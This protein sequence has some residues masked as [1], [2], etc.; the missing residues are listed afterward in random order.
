MSTHIQLFTRNETSNETGD[1]LSYCGKPIPRGRNRAEMVI[2]DKYGVEN[3][4]SYLKYKAIKNGWEAAMPC[5][6]F[7]QVDCEQ[8]IEKYERRHKKTINVC[9]A[10]TNIKKGK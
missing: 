5:C 7:I 1:S 6:V 3:L 10:K 9:L 4:Y 8:C 2:R